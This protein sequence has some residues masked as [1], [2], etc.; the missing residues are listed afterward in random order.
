[1]LDHQAAEIIGRQIERMQREAPA[2]RVIRR[3]VDFDL[4]LG[5]GQEL[6]GRTTAGAR[7]AEPLGFQACL[8]RRPK[9][10]EHIV[11]EIRGLLTESGSRGSI[12][13]IGGYPSL[14]GNLAPALDID[15]G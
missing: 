3:L 12:E 4:D 10:Q 5:I 2:V 11:L 14:F 8:S 13:N 1:M 9:A 6:D 15:A 7:E